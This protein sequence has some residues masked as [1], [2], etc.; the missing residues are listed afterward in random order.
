MA[1][2]LTVD[3][4]RAR[5]DEALSKYYQNPRTIITPVALHSKKYIVLGAVGN[6]K[7]DN[8]AVFQK[9]LD[10]AGRAGCGH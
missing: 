4:L 7:T 1:A 8:T 10:L 6:D 5:L 2:G 9:P 3:E